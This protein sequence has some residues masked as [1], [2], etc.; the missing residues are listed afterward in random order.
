MLFKRRRA[1]PNILI[2]EARR[3]GGA[4]RNPS[5]YMLSQSL[6]VEGES[7]P[8]LVSVRK[9]FFSALTVS[10]FGVSCAAY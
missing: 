7:P 6:D 1:K 3:M 4:T 8:R 10:I 5:L 2:C 9:G